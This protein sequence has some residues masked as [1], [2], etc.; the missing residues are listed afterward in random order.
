MTFQRFKEFIR[1]KVA[2]A[3]VAIFN[4]TP[5]TQDDFY[6]INATQDHDIWYRSMQH[7]TIK[8]FDRAIWRCLL[9]RSLTYVILILF[10][11]FILRWLEYCQSNLIMV[12]WI[13]F[14]GKNLV[15]VKI[16]CLSGTN[17]FSQWSILF[18]HCPRKWTIT[19]KKITVNIF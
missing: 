19:W 10:F 7:R 3:K 4:S 8:Q 1:N 12:S 16:I 17:I 11:P 18:G 9:I 14:L 5:V 2:T 13:Y 6:S 15:L